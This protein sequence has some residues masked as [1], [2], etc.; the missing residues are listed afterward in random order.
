MTRRITPAITLLLAVSF[1]LALPTPGRADYGKRD[2]VITVT[3]SEWKTPDAGW[4][5]NRV[6]TAYNHAGVRIDETFN[7]HRI[8]KKYEPYTG[9]SPWDNVLNTY[10]EWN[11][12]VFHLLASTRCGGGNC[13]AL[14]P[15][16]F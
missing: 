12:G 11:D 4:S 10:T 3:F 5:K 13:S 15:W 2:P 9:D 1:P 16:D 14:Q 7:P 8:V 6:E